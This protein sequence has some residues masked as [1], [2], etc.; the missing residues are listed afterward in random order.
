[1]GNKTLRKR[2]MNSMGN[3]KQTSNS[4]STRQVDL[5]IIGGRGYH[6]SY[7]GVENAIRCIHDEMS[8]KYD[9]KIVVYGTDSREVIDSKKTNS[10]NAFVYAPS[11][12]YRFFG[13]HGATL[14]CVLHALFISRPRVTLIFASGPSIFVPAFRV[15]RKPVI[16]SLRAID[17]SRDKWGKISRKIL[18]AG[19]YFAWR[20]S[21]SF[22]VN[23]KEMATIF[24]EK[25][26]D[27]LYIPNG[28]VPALD[29]E[30][31][32]RKKYSL[33][34]NG[35]FLFAAR[36][37]PVKRL[38][39]LLEAHA[40]LPK[41]H[42]LPLVIAGGHSKSEKY[43]QKLLKY[44][45]TDVIFLGHISAQELGPLMVRCRAFLLPSALEG[46]SNSLLSAMAT[47]C[48]VLA[49]DIPP[50]KD[51]LLNQDA[52]FPLDNVEV[53]TERL[54]RLVRD[55]EF[56]SRLGSALQGRAESAFSW[57]HT[58]RLFYSKVSE[59]L[60]GEK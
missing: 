38:H 24:K 7:G 48:A 23:S 36:L 3:A 19:E 25:R 1:M 5:A 32:I 34:D 49:S 33:N 54:L 43:R 35:Y 46:M 12:A 53:M 60:Q 11:F 45:A 28:S 52:I 29:G 13:Q 59:H 26:S 14:S 20:Y 42:R 17:S 9:L 2:F 15:F 41:E 47:G 44:A 22:T 30:S 56:A 50:N 10:D 37:D 31:I 18:Q 4:L 58:A 40:R 27:V 55:P 8:S 57:E 6:S 16:T 51:V 21:N 39:L